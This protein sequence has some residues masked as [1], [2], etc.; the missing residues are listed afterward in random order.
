[1]QEKSLPKPLAASA[2]HP[3]SGASN[4]RSAQLKFSAAGSFAV[5]IL[6]CSMIPATGSKL[7]LIVAHPDDETIGAAALLL[8]KRRGKIVHVTDGAP[9][10]LRDALA[11]GF[12]T[13]Q[14]YAAARDAE[15]RA[16]LSLAGIASSAMSNM[17]YTDQQVSFHLK[18]LAFELTAIFE[19][20]KPSAVLTHAYEGG[21]P[22]HDAV[23]LACS[24]AQHL[25]SDA[26]GG[27]P[28]KLME[29]AGYH[30]N[31]GTLTRNNFLT[32]AGRPEFHHQLT[33]AEQALKVK[34]LNAFRTQRKTLEAF[35]P[36]QFE[37]YRYAPAY[38]FSRAPH[39][40]TLWY[41][42]FD[43]GVDGVCWRALAQQA[44]REF[45]VLRRSA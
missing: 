6:A 20:E 7:L 30:G 34:M 23:A 18:K 45:H 33:P 17:Q 10:N 5:E 28:L 21:H 40:G 11:A 41:E 31:G 1:L 14:H 39:A 4:L 19:R 44:L 3:N 15:L 25:C 29:F 9:A 36:P 35:F 42:N 37:A 38:D 24:I 43:W 16:A 8:Q 12:T 13:R 27:T 32:S 26:C 2:S 22:D